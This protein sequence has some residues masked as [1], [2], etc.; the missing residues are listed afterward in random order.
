LVCFLTKCSY[1]K[2]HFF[3]I[4]TNAIWYARLNVTGTSCAYSWRSS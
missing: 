3:L 1:F 2:S 4:E